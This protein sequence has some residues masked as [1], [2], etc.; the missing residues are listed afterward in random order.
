[1]LRAAVNPATWLQHAGHP[2]PAPRI[3]PLGA[4][5]AAAAAT[6]GAPASPATS[7]V[8]SAPVAGAPWA[9]STGEGAPPRTVSRLA[10]DMQ[11]QSVPQRPSG[12][13]RPSQPAGG[14]IPRES[15]RA[16]ANP[17]SRAP[18]PGSA[19]L[20]SDSSSSGEELAAREVSDVSG[21]SD[22]RL[23]GGSF[24]AARRALAGAP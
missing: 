15:P 14:P 9:L 21:T 1:M 20:D 6:G 23:E 24:L 7:P 12:R 4:A 8:R 16:T 10:G 18:N 5:P 11:A 17:G 13:A 3:S 2:L 19:A 22:A